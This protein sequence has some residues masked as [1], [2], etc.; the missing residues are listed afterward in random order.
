MYTVSIFRVELSRDMMRKAGMSEP[1]LHKIGQPDPH[2]VERMY[3]SVR[4][5][6]C[7]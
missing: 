2:E 7:E 4:I 6:E 3:G 5:K 1:K